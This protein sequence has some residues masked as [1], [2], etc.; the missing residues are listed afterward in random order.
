MENVE[1]VWRKHKETYES[2]SR[3]R[4][5]NA[6]PWLEEV[7]PSL[8]SQKFKRINPQKPGERKDGKSW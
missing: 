1:P 2:A 6:D 4:K 3:C 5:R 8:R 7:G